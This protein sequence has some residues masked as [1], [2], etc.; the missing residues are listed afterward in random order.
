MSVCCAVLIFLLLLA[1]AVGWRVLAAKRRLGAAVTN[2]GLITTSTCDTPEKITPDCDKLLADPGLPPVQQAP[3]GR[4]DPAA[5]TYAIQVVARFIAYLNT[6]NLAYTSLAGMRAPVYTSIAQDTAHQLAA[7][8]VSADGTGAVVA[9]RGTMTLED[10][11]ADLKFNE[12]T[13]A[14]NNQQATITVMVPDVLGA[15]FGPIAVHQGMYGVYMNARAS[16]LAALPA[17]VRSVFVAGHSMGAAIAFYYALELA[18]KGLQVEVHGLAPPRAGNAAFAAA[19]A[20]TTSA[21]SLINMADLVPS[22]PWSYMPDTTDPMEPIEYAHVQPVAIFDARLP[23]IGS[24]HALP[25][26]FAGAPVAT[27]MASVV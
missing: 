10:L 17:T 7:T 26:Y 13:L 12:S 27:V 5:T 16:L 3:T 2:W 11:M 19:V 15:P 14:Q 8:W 20:S 18:Q 9:I 25:A 23:D 24:C 6:G 21:S 4:F 1:L 22:V